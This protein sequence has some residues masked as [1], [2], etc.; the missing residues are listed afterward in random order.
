MTLVLTAIFVARLLSASYATGWL[1]GHQIPQGV[2]VPARVVAGAATAAS[3]LMLAYLCTGKTLFLAVA[4]SFEA[5][6]AAGIACW[7]F[8]LAVKR[9]LRHAMLEPGSGVRAR[10][11]P[12]EYSR[13]WP[14][15]P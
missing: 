5:E 12:E 6:V 14:R 15:S 3:I 1:C 4:V 9:G 10:L 2:V 8:V 13:E 11:L 7:I